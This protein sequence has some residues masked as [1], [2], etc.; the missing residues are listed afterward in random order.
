M[1]EMSAHTL[2]ESVLIDRA[3]AGDTEAFRTLVEIHS[4]QVYRALKVP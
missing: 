2:P 3:R 4:D 1:P